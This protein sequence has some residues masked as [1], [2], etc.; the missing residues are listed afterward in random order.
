MSWKGGQSVP[1]SLQNN[2]KGMLLQRLAVGLQQHQ[3]VVS[4]QY[5][6]NAALS[7]GLIVPSLSGQHVSPLI[8]PDSMRAAIHPSPFSENRADLQLSNGRTS[9]KLAKVRRAASEDIFTKTSGGLGRRP[10]ELSPSIRFSNKTSFQNATAEHLTSPFSST[11]GV[12]HEKTIAQIAVVGGEKTAREQ[13]D[14]HESGWQ[15]FSPQV[16]SRRVSCTLKLDM[17][18][19]DVENVEVFKYEVEHDVARALGLNDPTQI[20]V[21]GLH[22][23]GIDVDIEIN[24]DNHPSENELVSQLIMQSQDCGRSL[25]SGIHTCRTV[26]VLRPDRHV[27]NSSQQ[28]LND[29]VMPKDFHEIDVQNRVGRAD[30]PSSATPFLSEMDTKSLT[31]D[32]MEDLRVDNKL[33]CH[34]ITNK[35]PRISSQKADEEALAITGN[36]SHNSQPKTGA[37]PIIMSSEMVFYDEDQ[38]IEPMQKSMSTKVMLSVFE[39]EPKSLKQYVIDNAPKQQEEAVPNRAAAAKMKGVLNASTETEKDQ[40]DQSKFWRQG[41][42]QLSEHST[43]FNPMT[44]MEDIN[45]WET[46]GDFIP[47][48][49][50]GD[51]SGMSETGMDILAKLDVQPIINNLDAS[52]AEK[53][54]AIAKLRT[55]LEPPIVAAGLTWEEF[56][57][58]IQ[59]ILGVNTLLALLQARNKAAQTK[60]R[61]QEITLAE[62][63]INMRTQG[64]AAHFVRRVEVGLDHQ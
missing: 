59:S 8:E 20:R 23:G 1:D 39:A 25:M 55:I 46:L 56:L 62:K 64:K 50:D 9:P 33:N 51:L 5:R 60:L 24:S 54:V 22:T 52:D 6:R 26:A 44:S 18:L 34:E 58:H 2:A 36:P 19:D 7:K 15:L 53:K 12:I 4:H 30:K 3:M 16:V 45:A 35:I 40:E 28:H 61:A 37:G 42:S 10:E 48:D 29:F 63:G 38:G 13:M 17:K 47:D 14:K 41:A 43:D 49:L 11:E 57:A 32:C 31:S 21:V 27:D